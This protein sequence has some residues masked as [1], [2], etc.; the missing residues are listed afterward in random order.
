MS[1]LLPS[2]ESP[3]A[4]VDESY[5]GGQH[6]Q[7]AYLLTAVIVAT[8]REEEVRHRLTRALPGKVHRSTG[9][10]TAMRCAAAW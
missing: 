6:G 10:R 4:F 7:G 8:A 2:R 5:R 9:T 3:R 1:D